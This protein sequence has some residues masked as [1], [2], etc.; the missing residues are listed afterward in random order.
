MFGPGWAGLAGLGLRCGQLLAMNQQAHLLD[1][2]RQSARIVVGAKAGL[3]GAIDDACGLDVGN[4]AFELARHFDAHAPV[5]L[6]HDDERAVANVLASQLP[7]A[8]HTPGIGGD[9]FRGRGGDHEH[10]DLGAGLIFQLLELL[11][12]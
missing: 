11:A 6:G 4:G 8:G 9:V 10:G 2:G 7:A 5:V 12:Q 1:G 3:H